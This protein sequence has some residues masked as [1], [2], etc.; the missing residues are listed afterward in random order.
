MEFYSFVLVTG[1][2]PLPFTQVY[3]DR[4]LVYILDQLYIITFN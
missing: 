2:Y 4:K 1:L 3:I